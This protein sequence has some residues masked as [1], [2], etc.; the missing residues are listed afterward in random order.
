[1]AVEKKATCDVQVFMEAEIAYKMLN[2]SDVV[3][4]TFNMT[5][6]PVDASDVASVL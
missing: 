2:V 5:D 1:M 4:I 6:V 3:K